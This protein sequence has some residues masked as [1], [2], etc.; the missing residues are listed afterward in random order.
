MNSINFDS[1]FDNI[2]ASRFTVALCHAEKG[3][4]SRVRNFGNGI[5]T[6]SYFEARSDRI[7]YAVVI[8]YD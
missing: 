4:F 7:V 2:I 8:L 1:S 6:L 5:N 3:R